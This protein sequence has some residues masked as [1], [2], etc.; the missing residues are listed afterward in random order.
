MTK[1]NNFFFSKIIH[2]KINNPS[3]FVI[4]KLNDLVLDFTTEKPN[5]KAV[6]IKNGRHISYILPNSLVIS[7][8]P[9]ENL[10]V[11]LNS[12]NVEFV[13]TSEDDI[14]LAK[15]FLDKQIVD[16]NG[17]KVERVNDARLGLINERWMLVAVDIGFRGLLRRL[18]LEYPSIRI[19]KMLKKEFR[20]KLIYWNNVQPLNTGTENLKLSTAM[21]KLETLHAADIAD[22]IEEL[23]KNSRISL[24]Q[25]LEQS[26][27]AEVFEEIEDDIQTNLLDEL[28]DEKA[29]NILESMP[30]DEAADVLGH[31]D[32]SRAEKL[33]VQMEHES[34]EEIRELMDYEENTIGSIM[35]VDY[36][37]FLPDKSVTE[38]FNYIKQETPD[39]DDVRYIYIV[40]SKKRLL[41][42]VNLLDLIIA[43]EDKK[44]YDLMFPNIVALLDEEKITKG[45]E[46]LQKY[47]LTYAPVVDN[48]NELIGLVSLNDLIREILQ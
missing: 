5:V 10:V 13:Q 16:I 23:D 9:E 27:A 22:I 2:K 14:F 32:E 3:G 1:L 30:P 21:T 25:S 8:D 43:G 33:L 26:I 24:F 40:N 41:G 28:S 17:K 44:L 20:N 46:L 12:N 38:V 6:E 35:S 47:N 7:K 34:S 15:D 36:L 18:G 19:T 29:S 48:K 45:F 31:I 37:S 42:Y 11:T 39:D 4:G